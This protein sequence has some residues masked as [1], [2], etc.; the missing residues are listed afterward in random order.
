M[1]KEIEIRVAVNVDILRSNDQ[2][3]YRYWKLSN[4]VIADSYTL[5]LRE[6]P[7]GNVIKEYT[8]N[9]IDDKIVWQPNA[10][11]FEYSEMHYHCQPTTPT[12]TNW[13]EIEGRIKSD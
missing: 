5:K 3:F 10:A 7:G 12:A 1:A 13:I 2:P 11:D 9:P 4:I 6:T 8:I